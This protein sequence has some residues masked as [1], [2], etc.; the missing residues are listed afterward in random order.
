MEDKMKK[1]LAQVV[2]LEKDFKELT[3][4]CK[5]DV[6]SQLFYE[7]VYNTEDLFHRI[8]ENLKGGFRY[9]LIDIIR[10]NEKKT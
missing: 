10:A 6:Q 2:R 3:L 1:I 8:I 4:N 9:G 5:I 7:H